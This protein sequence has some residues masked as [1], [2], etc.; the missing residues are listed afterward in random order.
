MPPSLSSDKPPRRAFWGAAIFLGCLLPVS[1]RALERPAA[2][3]ICDDVTDPLTL[4]PQSEFSEKVHTLVQQIFEGLVRFDPDGRI[5]P[6][7]A[8]SW[9]RIDDKTVEFKLREGV[10]FHDGEPFDADAVKFTIERYLDP[11]TRFPAAGFLNSIDKVLVVDPHTVRITTKFPDGILLNR[12][13]GF[14]LISPPRYLAEHDEDFIASHP[15]GTGAYHFVQWE[16]GKRI[17]L[18]ANDRYWVKDGPKFKSLVFLFLPIEKQVEGLING[19][20]DIVTELPGTD[21]LKVMSSGTARVVKKD[22]FYTAASSLN[23]STGPLS[24]VRVR[25]AINYAV[26]KADLVRYD[27][28]GNGR[29]IATMS[30]SGEMGHD[31][32]L[33]PY[34][35]DVAKAK[36]LLIAAGYPKGFR[37]DALVKVQGMRAMKI[38]AAHLSH[39]GI[40]VQ[41]TPTTDG[42]AVFDMSK[43]PWDWI[44]AGCPDPMGHSFFIQSIFLSS[45][46]PFSVTKDSRYDGL[47]AQMVNAVD[48]AQQRERGIELDD[49]IHEQALS[50]FTYQRIKTYGVA[51]NVEFVP[52]LTGMPYFYLT[53]PR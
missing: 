44:F 51:N 8:T 49:Y 48:T 1:A 39:V 25:Q 3:R 5:V 17:V 43:K 11:K 12:L 26:D 4:D 38:I 45:L 40:Q 53:S 15:V 7:L 34:P 22:S 20:V 32:F 37:L 10:V 21:T 2:L 36:Q 30:M 31:P 27:L 35:Y 41:I 50:L 52:W 33:K 42:Q 29:P 13:A 18:E 47:L 9:R 28:M 19:T 14:V 6:A 23:V 16:K 24:D 46:S